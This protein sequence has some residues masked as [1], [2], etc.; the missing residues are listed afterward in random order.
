M[1]VSAGE[2]GW[3]AHALPH[4]DAVVFTISIDE[5]SLWPPHFGGGTACTGSAMTC[6]YLTWFSSS[7]GINQRGW[8]PFHVPGLSRS[9]P[10]R[11]RAT[12]TSAPLGS[13]FEQALLKNGRFEIRSPIARKP[14][15]KETAI[16]CFGANAG[17]CRSPRRPVE[18]PRV[19]EV[20]PDHV[21]GRAEGDERRRVGERKVD[22]EGRVPPAERLAA[23]VGNSRPPIHAAQK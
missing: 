21:A 8:P 16:E 22:G 1:E 17:A 23:S 2:K 19:P 11:R 13:A 9:G 18:L 6:V 12:V 15:A 20:V 4:P 3:K 7:S 5:N 10:A 14:T